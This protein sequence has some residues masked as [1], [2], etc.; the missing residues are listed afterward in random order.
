MRRAVL[1]LS[2][3][4]LLPHARTVGARFTM[5]DRG[6]VVLN[7]SVHRLSSAFAALDKPFPLEQPER[8]LF[9]PLT[10]LS[11]AIDYALFGAGPA[12]FHVVNLALYALASVLVLFVA[13]RLL[14]SISAA[15]VAATWFALHP[16]HCEA[17][18][19][20]AGR[21]ELLALAFSLGA[22]LTFLRARDAGARRELWLATSVALC[23]AAALAKESGLMTVFVIGALHLLFPLPGARRA[24]TLVPFA[25]L[26]VLYI[27]LRF[28]ALGR[29]VP[30]ALSVPPGLPRLYSG[31][32][33]FLENV[34]L[35]VFPR[36]LQIDFY[37]W[38]EIGPQLTPT[39]RA[40]LGLLLAVL[41]L[42]VTVAA[43]I[44]VFRDPPGPRRDTRALLAFALGT[45]LLYLAPTSHLVGIGSLMG[46]RF[47]LAPSF[48][49][50]LVIGL[51]ARRASELPARAR[52][53]ALAGFGAI[54]IAFAGRSYARAGEWQDEVTLQRAAL[55]G[56][57][58]DPRIYAHLGRGLIEAGQ[59]DA[60]VPMLE[61]ALRLQP[62]QVSALNDLGWVYMN[63]GDLPRARSL[64]ERVLAVAPHYA[65]A[66]NS[67]GVIA[68]KEG[69]LVAARDL[70]NRAIAENPNY[71][72]AVENLRSVNDVLAQAERFRAEH[73][74]EALASSNAEL[75]L[76]LAQACLVTG[77]RACAAQE[78]ERARALGGGTV[79]D[80]RLD[81]LLVE[82]RG[83]GRLP[84]SH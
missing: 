34:R 26:L 45:T 3:L 70:Y 37:Y 55:E 28:H 19:S 12:G 16:V 78:Y 38:K 83:G 73:G 22:I 60:G 66:L 2:L 63:R 27:P 6:F 14:G 1:L 36:T 71:E 57:G 50:A 25:A 84:Q 33:V 21:S 30:A 72:R 17:V 53:V 54:M 80:G 69:N 59:E 79:S 32:A 42:G 20:I 11:Y 7:A 48:G 4:A 76:R 35:L 77:D 47:L 31:G 10:N 39:P 46:E 43:A 58:T 56:P 23:A 75:V 67:L 61:E 64:Y 24:A 18:D 68:T 74:G 65:L 44:S 15:I 40:I 5:D 82:R 52:H 13:R 8:G 62:D 9:R 49:A 29:F 51:L 41:V 81:A